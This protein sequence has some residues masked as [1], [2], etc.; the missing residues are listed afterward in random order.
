[1]PRDPNFFKKR[2]TAYG[3]L[4]VFTTDDLDTAEERGY[5]LKGLIS[6]AEISIWV[7]PPKCGKSFLM[8]Y[9]AYQLS[10]GTC[11]FGR[12]VRPTIVLYVAAEG[13]GGIAKRIKALRI[14]YGDSPNFHFIAQPADLLHK[15]GH[16]D[17]MK[18][19]AT[20]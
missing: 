1:M 14:R 8:L 7:G 16:L 2:G 11:V 15:H 19:A 4:S 9:I 6:S 13:E 3:R 5:L 20:R 17:E 18:C 12:R 10:L